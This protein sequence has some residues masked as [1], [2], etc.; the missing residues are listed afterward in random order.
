MAGGKETPRQKMIG[1]M[2]LVLL[3][4][5]AMNVSKQI[6]NAFVTLND[7]LATSENAIISKNSGTYQMFEGKM[8]LP[9]NKKIVQPWIDRAY[10]VKAMADN[11]SNFLVE[12]CSAM[13]EAVEQKKWHEYDDNNHATLLPLMEINA[14][15]NYDAPTSMFASPGKGDKRGEELRNRILNYRDSICYVMATYKEG[16]KNWTFT[17]TYDGTNLVEFDE[18]GQITTFEALTEALKTANPKDTAKIANVYKSL[19]QPEKIKNHDD[20][21]TWQES[22]FDHA[23]VVAAAA[24]FTAFIVDVRNAESQA[25][26]FLYAKVEV[27]T[28]NFNKIE[29]LAFAPSG[30]INQGDSIPLS[31][32]I[33]AYDSTEVPVIKYGMDADTASPDK[34]KQISGK[35][36]LSGDKPGLHKVKGVIMV[37]QKG[38]LVPKPWDFSYTVGAPMGVVAQPEMRILYIGYKNVI[39]GTASGFPADKV[40]LSGSGCSLKP[41]G[42]G[43]YTA[44]VSRGT[45]KAYISVSG[46]KDDGSSVSLGKFEFKVKP[47]P[48]AQASLGATKTGGKA[49][50]ASVKNAGRIKVGYDASVPLTNVKF[51][52]QGGSVTVAG[53]PGQGKI[54]GGGSLDSKSKSLL[55]Q[56]KNKQVTMIVKYKGPDGVGKM[57]ALVFNVR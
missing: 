46:Q 33:A 26:D 47:M 52:I 51:T 18:H 36:G 6:I 41:S 9:E 21:Y 28:F 39:E 57:T 43:Q 29:P 30:Y 3:A 53:V 37:K 11:L 44:S 8:A 54:S 49:S 7:K 35:I 2:Y 12:E 48:N 50:Y 55:R 16:K 1:M 38:E 23:P 32:M 22:V 45:K 19:S 13:I 4:M 14:K 17:P 56:S 15:D 34:W 40:S 25:A 20:M 10:N 27:P 42:N 24:M 5:L 31:V